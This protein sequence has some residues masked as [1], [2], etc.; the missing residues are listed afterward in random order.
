[1]LGILDFLQS[2][3]TLGFIVLSGPWPPQLGG[4]QRLGLRALRGF[5]V[6]RFRVLV[7]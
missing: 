5:G 3:I 6:S 4:W 2:L 1:M 7:H